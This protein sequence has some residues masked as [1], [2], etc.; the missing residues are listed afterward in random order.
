[1]LMEE[2][3]YRNGNRILGVLMWSSTLA[4]ALW[5]QEKCGGL[6]GLKI[7][8]QPL[9]LSSTLLLSGI[10][11]VSAEKWSEILITCSKFICK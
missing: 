6:I 4:S 11:A 7:R 9:M 1:M 8:N 3:A 10:S 2:E 5:A